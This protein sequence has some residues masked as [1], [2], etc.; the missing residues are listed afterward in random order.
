MRLE[1]AAPCFPP[2]DVPWVALRVVQFY[3]QYFP[4]RLRWHASKA[5]L[6]VT[7]LQLVEPVRAIETYRPV[8]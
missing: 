1:T 8:P 4:V 7:K 3:T 6:S 5:L 2:D